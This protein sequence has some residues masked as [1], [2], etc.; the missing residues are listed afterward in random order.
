VRAGVEDAHFH[1]L[2]AE[3]LSDGRRQGLSIELLAESATHASITTTE[4]Y[5]RGMEVRRSA[6]RLSIPTRKR[7]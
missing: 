1:D 7:G 2:R 4:G 6:L 3:A 5:L